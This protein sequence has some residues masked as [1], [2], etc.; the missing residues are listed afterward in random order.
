MSTAQPMRATRRPGRIAR[1][2][3]YEGPVAAMMLGAFA[4]FLASASFL[5]SLL[6]AIAFQAL[7]GWQSTHLAI[8]LGA[9]S[10]ST[11]FPAVRALLVVAGAILDEGIATARVDRLYWRT[12]A[13]AFRDQPWAAGILPVAAV[14]LG[15]D[16]ALMG[17]SD[18]VFLIVWAAVLVIVAFLIGLASSTAP[19]GE[20]TALELVAHTAVAI[21]R[22]PHVALAWLLIVALTAAATVLPVLGALA[23]LLLPAV[24]AVG[25][26]MCNR[27]LGFSVAQEVRR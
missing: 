18:T 10:L 8:W 12:L 4:C 16:L 24:S 15:Y 11:A 26:V 14:V 21:A 17:S 25:I 9:L 23:V 13:G 22:R 7:V 2:L 5:A 3:G 20:R 19:S 6:P 27:A 1:V